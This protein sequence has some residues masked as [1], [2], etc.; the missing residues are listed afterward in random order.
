MTT[1]TKKGSKFWEDYYNE[2]GRSNDESE[3]NARRKIQLSEYSYMFKDINSALELENNDTVADIG[4][5]GGG[6]SV[7]FSSL[8]K[9]VFAYDISKENIA[10]CKR[11]HYS[12][13]IEFMHG[14][15]EKANNTEINKMF[16]GAVFQHL[17]EDQLENFAVSICSEEQFPNLER[18]FISHI[19]DLLKQ[20]DWIDGYK[21]FKS[22]KKELEEIRFDWMNNCT[23]YG[24]QDL[25]KY[26]EKKFDVVISD[27][28]KHVIQHKYCFDMLLIKKK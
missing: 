8:V 6:V 15:I 21:N 1:F 12:D 22:D 26:F 9:K 16:L 19:P 23:W 28:N 3:M 10:Y 18:V 14:Y 13:N 25:K 5:A 17:S 2:K 24:S 11:T 7:L 4:C 20:Y 27:V